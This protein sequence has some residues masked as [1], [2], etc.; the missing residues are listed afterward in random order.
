MLQDRVAR[1]VAGELGMAATDVQVDEP[2]ALQ[3]GLRRRRHLRQSALQTES[4]PPG[5]GST[6]LIGSTGAAATSSEGEEA[7]ATAAA[8]VGGVLMMVLDMNSASALSEKAE[9]L[10]RIFGPETV[11]TSPSAES[12][13]AARAFLAKLDAD[14]VDKTTTGVDI[15]SPHSISR[16]NSSTFHLSRPNFWP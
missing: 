9:A 5:P 6:D 4:A 15:H 3:D 7:A 2:F 10:T 14:D 12:K 8:V 1:A 16:R 13:A 11:S